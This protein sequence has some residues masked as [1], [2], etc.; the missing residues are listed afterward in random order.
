MRRAVNW[1][2]IAV[3]AA[4]ACWAGFLVCMARLAWRQWGGC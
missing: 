2:G 4:V 1:E 3:L